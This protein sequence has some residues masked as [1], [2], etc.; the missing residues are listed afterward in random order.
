MTCRFSNINPSDL[1]VIIGIDTGTTQSAM[2][3][4]AYRDMKPIEHV[5]V[6][7]KDA[8]RLLETWLC[9]YRFHCLVAIE[10]LENHGMPIG[11]T[12]IETIIEIGRIERI[13]ESN[14]GAWVH[15]KR[16]E[17]KTEICHHPRATDATIRMELMNIYGGKGTKKNKGWFYGFKADEWQAYAIAHTCKILLER[18]IAAIRRKKP[19]GV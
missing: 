10:R 19:K 11:D 16:H 18:E 7:N 12:T 13:V 8:E 1:N 2:C 14:N 3:L 4:C 9:Q 15:I 6:D 5:K 17:E